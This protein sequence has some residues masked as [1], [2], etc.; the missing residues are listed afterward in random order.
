MTTYEG[1][2]TGF[3]AYRELELL[4]KQICVLGPI[5]GVFGRQLEQWL[6]S[7]DRSRNEE[8]IPTKVIV[9][10]IN[11]AQVALSKSW[12]FDTPNVQR[13]SKYQEHWD[14]EADSE[15]ELQERK[16]KLQCRGQGS[17][18]YTRS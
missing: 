15:E 7:P 3:L 2:Y 8:Y 5:A 17:D 10:S 9:K 16:P 4:G 12:L 13:W 18:R 14:D 1:Y 11:E 6:I